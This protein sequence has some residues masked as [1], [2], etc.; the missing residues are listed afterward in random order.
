MLAAAGTAV[1]DGRDGLNGLRGPL[2]LRAQGSFYVDG[3]TKQTDAATGLLGGL[4]PASSEEAGGNV[5]S[6]AVNQMY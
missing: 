6:I 5:G 4:F 2:I 1:A 3:Q